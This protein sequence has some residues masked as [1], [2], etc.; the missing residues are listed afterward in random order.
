MTE[1]VKIEKESDLSLE[2]LIQCRVVIALN[3]PTA[4][5]GVGTVDGIGAGPKVRVGAA[6][7]VEGAN[8]AT[9]YH[10]ELTATIQ[11]TIT[12]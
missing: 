8:G 10:C 3:N 9:S 12:A 6:T 4:N 2:R 1:I 5:V 11:N 7:M